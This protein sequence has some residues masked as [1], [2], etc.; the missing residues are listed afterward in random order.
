[1]N[2]PQFNPTTN[3]C[4]S[5]RR[6][7]LPLPTPAVAAHGPVRITQNHPQ[8]CLTQVYELD[9]SII[10]LQPL[11]DNA[12]A[13]SMAKVGGYCSFRQPPCMG[14]ISRLPYA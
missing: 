3:S 2:T 11:P 14:V 6:Q 5:T 13:V 4:S 7:L 9:S 10:S 1:M 8:H 12:V